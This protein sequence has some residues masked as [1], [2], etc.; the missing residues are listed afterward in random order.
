M[1]ETTSA[2][3]NKVD[4]ASSIAELREIIKNLPRD[5]F[6]VRIDEM[7]QS[8][9]IRSFNRIQKNVAMSKS[10]FFDV[11]SGKAKPQ[12][13]HIV[14]IGIAMQLSVLE[15]NELLKLAHHKEL[16][17]KNPEDVIVIYGIQNGMSIIEI[18]DELMKINA[19]FSLLEK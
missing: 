12:R 14:K 18:E 4:N 2:I 7:R 13:N 11:L 1:K 16:Y 17:A 5:S 9:N 6:C 8:H 15:I 10:Q 19:S 3:Q